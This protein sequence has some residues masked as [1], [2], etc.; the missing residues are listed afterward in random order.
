VA[1][2]PAALAGG[3]T[4]FLCAR[5]D[6]ESRAWSVLPVIL[7]GVIAFVGES[8]LHDEPDWVVFAVAIGAGLVVAL[9]V[10]VVRFFARTGT[11]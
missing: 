7:M 8:L 9:L 3:R 1:G 10:R 11:P 2:P 5:R 6:R 4:L